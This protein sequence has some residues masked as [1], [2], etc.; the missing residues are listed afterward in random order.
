MKDLSKVEPLSNSRG[1]I[2][3]AQLAWSQI[4]EDAPKRR[5]LPRRLGF[6]IKAH[7]ESR[8]HTASVASGGAGASLWEADQPIG[9]G[10]P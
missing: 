3:Q 7:V 9:P 4:K 8:T 2:A 1:L 5:A 6:C 10:L